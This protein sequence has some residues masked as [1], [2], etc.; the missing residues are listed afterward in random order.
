M[1]PNELLLW[2]SARQRGSWLQ[3]RSAIENLVFDESD[4]GVPDQPGFPLQQRLRFN[5]DHLGHVEFSSDENEDAWQ[6]APPVLAT[7]TLSTKVVGI[8]C[9]ARSMPILRQL[10]QASGTMA[11]EVT[12]VSECPDVIR[13]FATDVQ[14]LARVAEQAKLMFQPNAPLNLLSQLARVDSYAIGPPAEMP[15]GRDANI[16]R[17]V[18]ERKHSHW[19][20]L[21]KN[22][23]KQLDNGLFRCT[24]WQVSDHYLRIN[25]RTFTTSG[26]VGKYF[27]LYQKQLRVIQYHPATLQLRVLGIFRPPSLVDRALVLCSGFPPQEHYE[28]A[29]SGENRL[30]L[31]YNNVDPGVAGLVAELLYQPLL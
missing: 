23:V 21:S 15:F 19:E 18:V 10:K 29:S 12:P 27:L 6:V 20:K 9:G 26:Q 16:D 7:T 14:E 22:T 31:S 8:L 25:G 28:R 2:M 1:G 30:I 3:F 11:L 4:D 17:F 13:L 5:L 24:R